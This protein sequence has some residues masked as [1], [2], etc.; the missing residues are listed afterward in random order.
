MGVRERER[1]E[2]DCRE[3]DECVERLHFVHREYEW[4]MDEN[5]MSVEHNEFLHTEEQCGKSTLSYFVFQLER[6]FDASCSEP[7]RL[8]LYVQRWI[9]VGNDLADKSSGIVGRSSKRFERVCG[10][11]ND[12]Q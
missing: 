3:R 7:S 5:V 9:A 11:G 4:S 6:E 2:R 12:G 1:N 8:R 10:A